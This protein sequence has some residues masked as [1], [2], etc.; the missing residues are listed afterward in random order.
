MTET[1]FDVFSLLIDLSAVLAFAL[2]HSLFSFYFAWTI[3][4][5]PRHQKNTSINCL[6]PSVILL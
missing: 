2:V 4:S 5:E 3:S 1:A 6:Y